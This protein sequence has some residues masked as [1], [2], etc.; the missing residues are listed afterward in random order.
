MERVDRQRGNYVICE[1][2]DVPAMR[3]NSRYGVRM[4][5]AE[6]GEYISTHATVTEASNAITRYQAADKRRKA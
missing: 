2:V 5:G 3:P 1:T 6:P 4:A